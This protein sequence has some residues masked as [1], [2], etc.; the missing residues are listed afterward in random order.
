MGLG[1]AVGQ[2]VGSDP[3]PGEPRTGPGRGSVKTRN[4]QEVPVNMHHFGTFRVII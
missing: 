2:A 4:G 1:R 3:E